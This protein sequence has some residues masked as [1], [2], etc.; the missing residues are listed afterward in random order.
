MSKCKTKNN[1]LFLPKEE[2]WVNPDCFDLVTEDDILK[3]IPRELIKD[4]KVNI[5]SPSGPLYKQKT[6]MIT[7]VSQQ[8]PVKNTPWDYIRFKNCDI[9][10]PAAIAFQ[11]SK[12]AVAG[13]NLKPSYTPFLPGTISY[14]KFWLEELR[15]IRY[16]YEPI[17]DGGACGIRISGEFYFYLN[18]CVIQKI[19]QLE[20][21]TQIDRKDFPDF[22]AMDYFFFRELN[23]REEPEVYGLE[24]GYRSVGMAVAKARRKGF[25]FKA[26]AG[27]VWVT[28]FPKSADAQPKVLIASDTGGDAA[29]CFQKAMVCID[30]LSDYTPFGRQD[31]GPSK[32]SNLKLIGV[33]YREDGGNFVF[34]LENTK[35]RK[36]QGR[37]SVISTVSLANRADKAAGEGVQRLYIEE[38]GKV[39]NLEKV[40]EFTRPTLKVGTLIRGIAIIFGTGGEM[41][42]KD[43]GQGHSMGFSKLFNKPKEAELAKFKN[44]HEYETN[45]NDCGWFVADM[46]YD[47][48]GWIEINGKKYPSLD[49]NGNAYFWVAELN[50]NQQRFIREA[51]DKDKYNLFLTQHCKTPKEAFLVPQ[52]SVFPTADL[53]ARQSEIS[54]SKNGFE[55]L[56]TKGELV[57]QHG[58][59][60]FKPDLENRL[61]PLDTFVV[62]TLDREGCLLRYEPPMKTNG[63]VPEGAYII[64]VDPIGQNTIGG[65]SL[66]SIIVMKTPKYQHRFGP[67]KIVATYRGRAKNDPQGYVHQLLLK[68]SKYYNALI[69]F[70]NDRDGGILQFFI[71]SGELSRLMSKPELTLS[72]FL[73]NSKTNLREFGHS[74]GSKRHKQ[75]GE[76]LLLSWLLKRHKGKKV[77]DDYNNIHELPDLRNLDMLEDKAILEELIAYNRTGNFDT[78]MALMGAIIQINEHY[79]E[80]FIEYESE[81]N[82]VSKSIKELYINSTSASKK[83]RR[84]YKQAQ[85]KRGFY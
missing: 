76:D 25:S 66:S 32:E 33:S 16:G 64:T 28:A 40:W 10:R 2:I 60:I 27:A 17:V 63:K 55:K 8:D 65:K 24:Q 70:E 35:T 67:N 81:N 62:E 84:A 15:R 4:L 69:T 80:E 73:P 14:E 82:S 30:W 50:L 1:T 36:Q 51:A 72:K 42:K 7:R 39:S 6:R 31:P 52:G 13:T 34:G 57:E 58:N 54:M 77:V 41:V 26:A 20:D 19:K 9:F 46:W 53:V 49:K 59:V 5:N 48:G 75:I 78:V 79:D 56:R 61:Y 45:D 74:M 21:G 11:T 37:L 83:E 44:I 22:L 47:I 71:K 23:A 3:E 85:N 18:Y 68:L 29:K 43:G 38:S 12:K